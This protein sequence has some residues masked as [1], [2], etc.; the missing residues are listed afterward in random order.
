MLMNEICWR[1]LWEV[2][3]L[4]PPCSR[5][6]VREIPPFALGRRASERES[7]H[8]SSIPFLLLSLHFQP[9]T[10]TTSPCWI[11][12]F[13]CLRANVSSNRRSFPDESGVHRHQQS[14]EIPQIDQSVAKTVLRAQ[15]PISA[16]SFLWSL[17][18]LLTSLVFVCLVGSLWS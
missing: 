6:S 12:E 13:L 14:S 4:L 18:W 8:L 1:L 15:I 7:P 9:I 11:F 5:V 17:A 2:P 10:A 3:P 16:F